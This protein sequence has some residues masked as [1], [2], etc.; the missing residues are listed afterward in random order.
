MT[1]KESQAAE[2]PVAMELGPV[3]LAAQIW[4]DQVERV[5]FVRRSSEEGR[6][7]WGMRATEERERLRFVF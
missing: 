5:R 2:L 7:D 4:E 1:G 3:R 6:A